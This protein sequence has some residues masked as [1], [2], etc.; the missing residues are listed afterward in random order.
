VFKMCL[1][2]VLC[3]FLRIFPVAVCATRVI[4]WE[5]KRKRHLKMAIIIQFIIFLRG[6]DLML[7]RSSPIS[8]CVSLCGVPREIQVELYLGTLGLTAD[9]KFVM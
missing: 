2:H 4:L 1:T 7:S 8:R 5:N 9:V 6:M 3:V